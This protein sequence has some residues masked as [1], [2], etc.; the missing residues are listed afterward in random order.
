MIFNSNIFLFAFLPVS[1]R[2]SG[3]QFTRPLFS[4]RFCS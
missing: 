1:R 4:S 2:E 3:P